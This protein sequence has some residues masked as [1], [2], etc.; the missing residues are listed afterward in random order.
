MAAVEAVGAAPT[1]VASGARSIDEFLQ[2]DV[3]TSHRMPNP[4]H[5][6]DVEGGEQVLQVFGQAVHLIVSQFSWES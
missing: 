3:L 2:D 6:G 1:S 5:V 4:H